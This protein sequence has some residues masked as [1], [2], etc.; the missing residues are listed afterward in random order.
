[1]RPA[2]RHLNI[3]SH[4]IIDASTSA[5]TRQTSF[6][7]CHVSRRRSLRSLRHRQL[8]LFWSKPS[9][10]RS[11][12]LH[13]KEGTSPDEQPLNTDVGNCPQHIKVRWLTDIHVQDPADSFRL[14][15]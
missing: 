10:R 4:S 15:L 13:S 8:Q 2:D 7:W 6:E 3:V 9:K 1:M 12:P 5:S 14:S 11:T